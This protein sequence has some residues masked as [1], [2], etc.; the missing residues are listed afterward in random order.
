MCRHTTDQGS[1][2][3]PSIDFNPLHTSLFERD[4]LDKIA[5]QFLLFVN[6]KLGLVTGSSLELLSSLLE[7]D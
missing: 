3:S 1:I 6:S 7:L 5:R 2:Y 4:T